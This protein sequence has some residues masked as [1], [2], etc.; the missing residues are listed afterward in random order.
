[1][2]SF[3]DD[4]DDIASSSSSDLKKFKMKSSIDTDPK[5]SLT[6]EQPIIKTVLDLGKLLIFVYRKFIK[7]IFNF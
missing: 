1:L 3:Q 6:K 5:N 7:Y 4:D 2:L